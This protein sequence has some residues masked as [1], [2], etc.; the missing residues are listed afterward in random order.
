MFLDLRA[1]LVRQATRA[2]GSVTDA[3]DVVQEVWLRWRR[4]QPGVTSARAWLRTVTKNV[5]LDHLRERK[6]RKDVDLGQATLIDRCAALV[7]RTEAVEDLAP[8]FRLLLQSLSPLER[9][10]F[11]LHDG[12]AWTYTDISRMLA[13]SEQTVRQLRHRAKVNLAAGQGRFVAS[14][15]QVAVVSEAYVDVCAGGEVSTLLEVL[16]PDVP[17]VPPG[18]RRVEHRLLHEVAGIVLAQGDRLLLCHRRAELPWYPDV[19]DVPGSH[20]MRG[21]PAIACAMRAAKKE[22]GVSAGN[23]ELLAEVSGYD[24]SLTLIQATT[25]EGEPSN[26]A[27]AEHDAIGFFTRE[28]ASRLHLANE[29]YV[30]LFDHTAR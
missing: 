22:V 1:D 16:A 10:V 27:P 14:T 21:E 12:L 29:R 26:V 24:F 18:L 6:N 19:W 4:H 7:T 11:V 8:A 13:R 3:E 28:Q 17:L 25:W 9:A 2:L 23:P 30:E 20:L 15:R 5:V